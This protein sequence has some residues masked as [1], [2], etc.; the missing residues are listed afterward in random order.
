MGLN[1]EG[2]NIITPYTA[3]EEY[4]PSSMM[5]FAEI[6]YHANLIYE[7]EN[8]EQLIKYYHSSIGSH[9]K[10]NLIAAAKAGYLK[11]CPGLNAKAII[12]YIAVEDATKMG[13][14]K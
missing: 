10:T 1:Y 11:W 3:P 5:T 6:E 4:D 2:A 12:K 7:C 8:K 9:P 14:M 13:H